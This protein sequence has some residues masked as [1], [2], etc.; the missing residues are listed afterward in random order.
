[1]VRYGATIIKGKYRSRDNL[2]GKVASRWKFFVPRHVRVSDAVPDAASHYVYDGRY[3]GAFIML[4]ARDR[5]ACTYAIS[6]TDAPARTQ[7]LTRT[8]ATYSY[9]RGSY[10]MRIVQHCA[11]S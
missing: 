10:I 5:C 9:T 3:A 1:M 6:E 4:A 8:R 2:V 11:E 7:S